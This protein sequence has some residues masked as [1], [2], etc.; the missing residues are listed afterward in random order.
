[1]LPVV[2][3]LRIRVAWVNS[4][5]DKMFVSSSESSSDSSDSSDDSSSD[6]SASSLESVQ[7]L[8]APKTKN[9]G[10]RPPTPGS[11]AYFQKMALLNQP[12]VEAAPAHRSDDVLC[13]T[14]RPVGCVGS[15]LVANILRSEDAH[16]PLTDQAA[17]FLDR[18]LGQN[19][20]DLSGDSK[21]ALRVGLPRQTL[22]RWLLS[23]GSAAYFGSRALA[24]SVI[25]KYI[26]MA[27]A[28]T[29]EIIG[30]FSSVA[31]D[32]TP[33][34]MKL[35]KSDSKAGVLC[36]V[37]QVELE[38]AILSRCLSSGKISMSVLQLPCPVQV[39]D[40]G[41]GE[42]LAAAV[43]KIVHVVHWNR[44]RAL[45]RSFSAYE[46]DISSADR[47]AANDR[48]ENGMY[49]TSGCDRL[50][51]PCYAHIAS[52]AQARAMCACAQ[53]I[54]GVIHLSL[55]Q[56]PAGA[57]DEFRVC[58]QRVLVESAVILDSEPLP[59]SHAVSQQ[60]IAVLRA[61]LPSTDSGHRR[62][63]LLKRLL[64]GDINS[65]TVVIRISGESAIQNF[66]LK[67]WAHDVSLALLPHPIEVLQRHRWVNSLTPLSEYALIANVHRLLARAGYLWLCD[68]ADVSRTFLKQATGLPCA[69]GDA[70]AAANA[71]PT[72][73]C[74]SESDEEEPDE[75]KRET[76]QQKQD[77]AQRQRLDPN[78]NTQAYNPTADWVAWNKKQ[79]QKAREYC[80]SPFVGETLL[81][82]LISMKICVAF[83][84]VVEYVGS[85][86]WMISSWRRCTAGGAGA[87]SA[88]VLEAQNGLFSSV[89]ES[90]L[91]KMLLPAAW[92]AMGYRGQTAGFATRAFAMLY[93][94]VCSLHQL[95]LGPCS[96]FPYAMFEL[97]VRPTQD[98]ARRIL[99]TPKCM[100]DEWSRRFL[101]RY[102]SDLLLLSTNCRAVL[103]A[104]ATLIRLD[105]CRIECRHNQIRRYAGSMDAALPALKQV[106]AKFVLNRSR[107]LEHFLSPPARPAQKK[108][109][110]HKGVRK[111]NLNKKKSKQKSRQ[112]RSGGGGAQRA[113]NSSYFRRRGECD[114]TQRSK[115]FSDMGA[116]WRNLT[117]AQRH[118]F[119]DIGKAGT[120]SFRKRGFAYRYVSVQKAKR[121]RVEQQV[122]AALD[123]SSPGARTQTLALLLAQ[124]SRSLFDEALPSE[125]VRAKL[126]AAHQEAK[127]VLSNSVR[128]LASETCDSLWC[129]QHERVVAVDHSPE[130]VEVEMFRVMPPAYHIG[131]RCFAAAKAGQGPRK[132]DVDIHGNLQQLWTDLHGM[133]HAYDAPALMPL[134]PS[135]GKLQQV[136][137]CARAA[138]CLC[139]PASATTLAVR[140]RVGSFLRQAFKKGSP[141]RTVY[142]AVVIS[143]VRFRD[144]SAF[145][146]FF[147]LFEI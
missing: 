107:L 48:A 88:R 122:P 5:D 123:M 15:R 64:S 59:E 85:D 104:F 82:A 117:A 134:P 39:L 137:P 45:C 139:D 40:R 3:W 84:R 51:F 106:S 53:T 136:S 125:L 7:R 62:F 14:V 146:S 17:L 144:F 135:R 1:M 66:D 22:S 57:I 79:R 86:K 76:S 70:A 113:F 36:K 34:R 130:Q 61:C 140:T 24:S 4:S 129:D 56:K 103:I 83:L 142:P 138:R 74:V 116:A 26:R 77:A 143:S 127:D 8:V 31:Y 91:S 32:E 126:E 120:L 78:G 25:S 124:P 55:C 105:I 67:Q 118:A 147:R 94:G 50:R 49:A 21:L 108:Q 68:G 54:T 46:C 119:G 114:W 58:I 30:L 12:H 41:T 109:P 80:R 44:L 115:T 72:E 6:D 132:R 28:K 110:K 29:V 81:T 16:T 95:A 65:D 131:K 128:R 112:Q 102:D 69:R 27:E 63:A 9:V 23:L 96:R 145:S 13:Q 98:V 19:R 71:I 43:Q 75:G 18:I 89:V 133:H 47:A 87:Y 111:R 33:L 37:L 52:T 20:I 141:G 11:D 100:L 92:R 42:N 97:I 121:P 93:T 10:G 101:E 73:L 35:T 38:L 2:F 90:T 60:L 99:A